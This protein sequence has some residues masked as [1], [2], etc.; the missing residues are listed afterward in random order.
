[1][2]KLSWAELAGV[3]INRQGLLTAKSGKFYILSVFHLYVPPPSN[4]RQLG[5]GKIYTD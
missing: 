5:G 3:S 1:M 2:P 4:S